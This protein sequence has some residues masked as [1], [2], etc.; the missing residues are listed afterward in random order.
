MTPVTWSFT[1]A[2]PPPPPPDQGP[3]G[4]IALV[5]SS[6]NPYSK[7]LAEILRTEGLNEFTTIDVSTLSAHDSGRLRRRGAWRRRRDRGPGHDADHLG[8]WRRQPDRD[9]AR[10]HAVQPAGHHQRPAA[11]AADA[12]LKVDTA[13]APGAGIVSDTIQ[14]HGTADRYSLSGAQADRDDL[15]ERHALRRPFPAV[16]L[17]D[18][19]TSGGQAAA[20]TFDLARSV[21]QT[22]QGNPPGPAGARRPVA[23]PFRRHVLRRQLPPTGSTSTRSRFRRPTS[24][25]GCWPT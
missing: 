18:V 5:T 3:G 23:D 20:F 14:Y 13:T 4:P 9:E 22:R 21:V 6:S 15:F 8:Q 19:G 12:Y 16:T 7:Y 11:P 10:Q 24:S 1:T 2:A 25:S 17:R